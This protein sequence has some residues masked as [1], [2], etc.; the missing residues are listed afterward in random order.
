MTRNR[1][2]AAF[3]AI[4]LTS[5]STTYQLKPLGDTTLERDGVDFQ[6]VVTPD[7][8]IALGFVRSDLEDFQV[9][10]QITNKLQDPIDIYSGSFALTGAKTVLADS[11]IAASDPDAFLKKVKEEAELLEKRANTKNWEGVEILTQTMGEGAHK[12]AEV[13]R[14]KKEHAK[15]ERERSDNIKKAARLREKYAQADGKLLRRVTIRSGETGSGLVI[16]PVK[17]VDEGPV[18]VE[19]K[20]PNCSGAAQFKVT[21]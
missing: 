3:F 7:C 15:N 13:E 16:F 17:V 6:E 10:A 2:L 8:V 18:S 19:V 4:A 5:C 12:D 11:P 14:L 9:A 20:H 21:N 1:I